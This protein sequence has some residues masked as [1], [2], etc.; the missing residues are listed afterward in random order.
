MANEI[1]PVRGQIQAYGTPGSMA[2]GTFVPA[3]LPGTGHL[4]EHLE[5]RPPETG[6]KIQEKWARNP[7]ILVIRASAL[8][9]LWITAIWYRTATALIIVLM[10]VVFA[11]YS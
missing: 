5:L 6:S 2:H 1:E 11:L 4:P 9:T 3:P 10:I 7:V 8:G